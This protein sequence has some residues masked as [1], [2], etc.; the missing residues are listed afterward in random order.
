MKTRELQYLAPTNVSLNA[1]EYIEC[2]HRRICRFVAPKEKQRRKENAVRCMTIDTESYLVGGTGTW[3]PYC[4]HLRPLSI[5]DKC[6]PLTSGMTVIFSNVLSLFDPGE[7]ENDKVTKE[8]QKKGKNIHIAADYE[9]GATLLRNYVSTYP[10]R[11]LCGFN[12]NHDVKQLET[13]VTEGEPIFPEGT[14]CFCLYRYANNMC[15]NFHKRYRSTNK[16]RTKLGRGNHHSSKL[17]HLIAHIRDDEHYEQPH[18]AYGDVELNIELL[19]HLLST[20]GKM[21]PQV[22]KMGYNPTNINRYRFATV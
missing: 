21:S 16:F 13:I 9:E 19:N 18:T 10:S 15:P 22:S 12:V 17:E 6:V 14:R 11:L 3:L 5:T 8:I 2:R 7:V 4:V 20:D 1:N